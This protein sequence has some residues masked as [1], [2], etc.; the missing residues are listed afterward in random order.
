MC[1]IYFGVKSR[2]LSSLSSEML[3]KKTKKNRKNPQPD[4]PQPDQPQPDQPLNEDRLSLQCIDRVESLTLQEL[5]DILTFRAL[6]A[7]VEECEKKLAEE[8]EKLTEFSSANK[9]IVSLLG[10]CSAIPLAN[11]FLDRLI[12]PLLPGADTTTNVSTAPP[13]ADTTTNV[14]TA[15][16]GADTRANVST[17]PPQ[18]AT[19]KDSFVDRA[20]AAARRKAEFDN[21]NRKLMEDKLAIERKR[22]LDEEKHLNEELKVLLGKDKQVVSKIPFIGDVKSSTKRVVTLSAVVQRQ[23]FIC[24]TRV[25]EDM[26]AFVDQKKWSE[27]T[28]SYIG[29]NNQGILNGFHVIV[30][31][32]PHVVLVKLTTVSV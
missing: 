26:L 30:N 3:G 16:P 11:R 17:A 24:R 15:P 23:E 28:V 10:T 8:R 25:P 18:S 4:Q 9:E 7:N 12:Y 2:Y 14:S 6:F 22:R 27:R 21:R 20:R 5:R 29:L 31:G 13:G 1:C 19:D 32:V